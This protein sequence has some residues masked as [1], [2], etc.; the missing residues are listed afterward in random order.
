VTL[1]AAFTNAFLCAFLL[2]CALTV[3]DGVT[4]A[5]GATPLR[6]ARNVVAG[7][8]FWGAP[9]LA[10]VAT[11]SR[12]LPRLALLLLAL[13]TWW[14]NFG[15][16]PLGA[17]LAT[18]ALRDVVLGLVQAALALPALRSIRR[19]SEGRARLL[20]GAFLPPARPR[21]RRAIALT[22][23]AVP[24]ALVL[25]LAGCAIY[26]AE[27]AT[28]GFIGFGL[29]GVS[30]DERRYVRGDREV[31]LVGMSHVGRK[32]VYDALLQQPDRTPTLV[33]AEGVTDKQGLLPREQPF[34][35]LAADLGLDLQPDA[36]T[37]AGEAEEEAGGEAAPLEVEHA[38]LDVS[39]FRPS[40]VEFLRLSFRLTAEPSDAEARAAFQAL[41]GGPD[42]ADVYRGVVDD[43]LDER[44]AHVLARVDEALERRR[45]VVVPWGALHLGGIEAGLFERGFA[46]ASSEPRSFLPYRALIEAF[47][48]SGP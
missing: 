19:G 6:G 1:A 13:G 38:D 29:G 34:E 40:T 47:T 44:N 25:S 18:P 31:V 20:R 15:G 37:M 24:L 11:F 8:V 46:L 48:R 33:L 35:P 2:D 28:G 5:F 23:A 12:R 21:S 26:V 17:A 36:E 7:F 41:L 45:R 30:F 42:A 3:A 10:L 32:G 16:P 14:V 39:A 9:L 4:S 43:V 27:R 22:I